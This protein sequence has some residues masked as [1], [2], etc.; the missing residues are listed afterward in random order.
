VSAGAEGGERRRRL[1]Q[2]ASAAAFLTIVAVAVAIVV[3][4]TSTDGGDTELEEVGAINRELA[5]IPQSGLALGEPS[6]PALVVEYGD[7]KCPVCATYAEEVIPEI[8]ANEVRN[9][10]ARIEFRNFIVIDEQSEEAGAAAIAAGAQGRG[11]N[12]IEIFYAN[13]GFESEPYADEGFLTAVARAAGVPNLGRWSR[14]RLSAATREEVEKT[15]HE[16]EQVGFSGT[17]SFAVGGPATGGLAPVEA[18]ED[19]AR[20]LEDAIAQARG[21]R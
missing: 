4:A 15:T 8:V 12:F 16:A 7:L 6:A 13:Q 20:E 21:G 3:N 19:P 5:G 10:R 9:G 1:L 14:E 17:P 2:L 11:W 18:L